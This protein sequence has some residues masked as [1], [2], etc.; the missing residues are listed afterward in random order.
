[1]KSANIDVDDDN[2]KDKFDWN[3]QQILYVCQTISY[4]TSKGKKNTPKHI[5]TGL[6]FH[7]AHISKYIIPGRF[8]QFSADS[9]DL[10]EEIIDGK[11]TSYVTQMAA[12]QPFDS[13]S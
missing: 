11:G 3:H 6:H 9:L 10:L 8:T 4:A 12:L 5:R 2:A 13:L 7:H 1:M